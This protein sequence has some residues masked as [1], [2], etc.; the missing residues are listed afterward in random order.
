MSAS[1]GSRITE[2]D[3]G[4]GWRTF[5]E[6]KHLRGRSAQQ[7]VVAWL[8]Y[9]AA[10]AQDGVDVELPRTRLEELLGVGAEAA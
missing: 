9:A 2:A 10:Q 1:V 3:L 6:L 7:Q 8:R 5:H 4:S